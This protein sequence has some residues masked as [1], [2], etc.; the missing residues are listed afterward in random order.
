MSNI[1]DRRIFTGGGGGGN[2]TALA[3]RITVLE[4]N[5]Y[6]VA[7]F[8]S[9]SSDSG[10]ITKPTGSTILT[11]QFQGGIDAYVTTLSSGQP[12]GDN[13]VTAAGALVDVTSFDATGAY[14]LTGVPSAYPVGLI[15][16]LTIS[17]LNW[18]NL[19]A[20]NIIEYVKVDNEFLDTE[21]TIK[22]N[23]DQTKKV[24]FQ[25][26]GITTA[27]TRT[28]TFKDSTGTLA[29]TGDKLSAFAATTSAELAGVISDEIGSG[30]LVFATANVYSIQNAIESGTP[31]DG[32]VYYIGSRNL[33][34][35]ASTGAGNNRIYIPKAGTIVYARVWWVQNA[36]TSETS[37]ISVRLNNTTDTAISTGVVNNATNTTVSATLAITVAEGDYVELKWEC[38]T[39]ATN[40]TGCT[41]QWSLLIQ[42][43]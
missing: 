28:K 38:P 39:W 7:Y 14:V 8:A 20:A 32:V 23:A 15:Y 42:P 29:E 17:A 4:N 5:V 19:T 1:R 30:G 27:T 22:D 40:P 26:S 35:S 10:T 21:L 41:V 31:G 16:I 36:G 11:D 3:S 33:A 2:T 43:S 18:S 25:A 9:I 6:K 24:Q 34:L 12:T 37:T 13:P